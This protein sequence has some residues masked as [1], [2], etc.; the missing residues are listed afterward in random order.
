VSHFWRATFALT[1]REIVRFL[2]QRSRVI[3]ALITPLIFWLLIGAGF[4]SSFRDPNQGGSYLKFFFPGALALSVLFTAIFSTM[5]VIQDRHEGFLQGVIVAPISR[6][7]LVCS[8]IFGGAILALIQGGLLLLVCPFI[9][10]PLNLLQIVE[11]FWLL[12]LM[13][14]SLTGLGFM[15][16]WKIDSVQGYHAMMNVL[17]MPMWMM[18]GAVFP[19][20]STHVIFKWIMKLNPLTYGVQSLR[21]AMNNSQGSE[22]L[23]LAT[24]VLGAFALFGLSVSN[25][26]I[27]RPA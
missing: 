3:G 5:S 15:L 21:E 13:G 17:L 2:R 27:K 11:I 24:I 6:A 4:G 10:M 8:K 20:A 26:L 19:A 14:T 25:Y 12:F 18:S 9:G 7:A 22:S 16:A 1:K 23:L